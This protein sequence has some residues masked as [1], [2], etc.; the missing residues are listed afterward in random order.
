MVSYVLSLC[1]IVRVRHLPTFVSVEPAN[2]CQLRCP[3]CPVGQSASRYA[4]RPHARMSVE[5]FRDILSQIRSSCHTIQFYFQG[6]P[7]LNSALPAMVKMSHEAGLFTVVSTNAQMLDMFMARRLVEAG[8]SRIIVSIDGFSEESYNAY[9]AGGSLQ[10]ALDGLRYLRMAREE[11]GSHICIELQVLR[12]SSNE[13]EWE[14]IRKHY[15]S[16]G[17]TRL[18]F[19]TAQ[20]YDYRHGHVLMP[21]KEH[22]SR[23]RKGSD[24]L[25]YL[26]RAKHRSCYRLWSGCVIT[27]EGDVIACCYDK[28]VQHTFGNISKDTLRTL[29]YGDKANAFRKAVVKNKEDIG[30]CRECWY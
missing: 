3:E 15:T 13:S 1:G 14:W 12:L 5:L 27:A 21:S 30:M 22:Y 7:L 8:L 23:Y 18:V 11:Y 26:H 17:A 2:Y 9:R 25:Y 29:W 16:L 19:K 28:H 10:C 24:G 20:L 6:E 4:Q